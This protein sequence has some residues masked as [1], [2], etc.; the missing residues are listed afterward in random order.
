MSASAEP[1][2]VAVLASGRGS[3]L[4][5]LIDAAGSGRLPITITGVISDRPASGA[6]ARARA[7][8]IGAL[9]IDPTVHAGRAGFDAALVRLLQGVQPQ[10]IVCAGFMRI[11]GADVLQ[12]FFGRMINI[13]PSLLPAYPGLRTHARALADGVRMHGASL[14]FVTPELDAGPVFACA[15]VPVLAGDSPEALAARVL[16]REHPLLVAGVGLIAERRI[17][18]AAG[19]VEF[20]GRPLPAALALGSD[21]A[22]HPARAP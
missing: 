9:A 19:G 15:R 2:R 1:L 7:H 8:G 14:H 5:A 10:L 4:Q 3:N 17:V 16:E 13:H 12:P 20:D 21:D 6:L 22:L 18:L 11:I